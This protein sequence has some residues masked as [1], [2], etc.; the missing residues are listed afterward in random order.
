MTHEPPSD[1]RDRIIREAE[2]LAPRLAAAAARTVRDLVA[3][4]HWQTVACERA[5]SAY[6]TLDAAYR[7]LVNPLS[8]TKI[9]VDGVP[10]SAWPDWHADDQPVRVTPPSASAGVPVDVGQPKETGI[11]PSFGVLVDPVE[12]VAYINLDMLDSNKPKENDGQEEASS[13]A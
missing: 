1:R 13:T 2:E 12:G 7:Q 8:R 5:R 10:P 6:E 3:E 11:D 9:V 4:L